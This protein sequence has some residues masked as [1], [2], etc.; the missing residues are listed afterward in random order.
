MDRYSFCVECG[1]VPERG[2]SPNT[3]LQFSMVALWKTGVR[4]C[5]PQQ[6]QFT[7]GGKDLVDPRMKAAAGGDSRFK[8]Q[9]SRFK[10]E[11]LRFKIQNSRFK[12]RSGAN[13]WLASAH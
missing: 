6:S 11:D 10:V 13:R 9:D 5:T 2:P 4:D 7:I 3:E 1:E 12:R 8:I